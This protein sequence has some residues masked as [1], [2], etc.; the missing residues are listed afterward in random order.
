MIHLILISND[1]SIYYIMKPKL[2]QSWIAIHTKFHNKKVNDDEKQCEFAKE[3]N[4]QHG[5]S[6]D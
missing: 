6:N 4:S 5:E 1:I 3:V 2:K